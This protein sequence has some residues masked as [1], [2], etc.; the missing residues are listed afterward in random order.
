MKPVNQIFGSDL[1]SSNHEVVHILMSTRYY[2]HYMAIE[3][4][5]LYSMAIANH[6]PLL[7]ATLAP[8]ELL[9]TL[10]T[11]QEPFFPE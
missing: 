9:P 8:L 7:E 10:H 11:Y 5:K 6:D 4:L 3:L 2:T 1:S